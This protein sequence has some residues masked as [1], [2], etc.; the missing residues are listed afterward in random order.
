MTEKRQQKS[1]LRKRL[2][3]HNGG[4]VLYTAQ[5]KPWKLEVYIAFK[6]NRLSG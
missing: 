2:A 4:G 1:H 5:F 3:K 6:T